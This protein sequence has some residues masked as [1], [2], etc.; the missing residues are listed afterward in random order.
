MAKKKA[1]GKKPVRPLVGAGGVLNPTGINFLIKTRDLL[2]GKKGFQ[3]DGGIIK[4]SAGKMTESDLQKKEW[5]L[6]IEVLL[7]KLKK[8]H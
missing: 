7:I 4:A 8:E 1:K 6:E 5:Q 2:K 3:K